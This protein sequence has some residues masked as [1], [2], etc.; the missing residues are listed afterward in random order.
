MKRN[1]VEL[2]QLPQRFLRRYIKQEI[3]VG[4]VSRKPLL[5]YLCLFR[6]IQMWIIDDILIWEYFPKV[7][8][9]YL[10][11]FL[12]GF[13]AGSVCVALAMYSNEIC[14]DVI[15]GR[16]GVF[17]DMMQ[18]F[19]IS[20]VYSVSA[21]TTL[22]WSSVICLCIPVVFLCIFYWMPESPLHSI[23]TGNKAEA[24]ESIRYLLSVIAY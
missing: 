21:V 20:F 6:W 22:F 1:Y 16:S 23:K 4:N 2:F 12:C 14:C 9:L 19:G 10:G 15:R 8:F 24:I 11:R 3:A 17:Y 18:V 5:S 7:G 13:T